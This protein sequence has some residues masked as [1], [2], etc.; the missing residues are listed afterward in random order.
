DFVRPVVRG[1][2]RT[3]V[4]QYTVDEV[5]SSKR[6][7]LERDLDKQVRAVF[8]AKGLILDRFILRNVAFSPEYA[9]AV[10]QKQVALQAKIES[11]YRADAVRKL[12]QGEADA[13]RT[14]AQGQA[15]A[16]TLIAQALAKDKNLLTY[17][18]IQKLSPAIRVMLVPSNAPFILP[19]PT[20]DDQATSATIA[21]PLVSTQTVTST[22]T[23]PGG[24]ANN[25]PT[26]TPTRRP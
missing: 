11:E 25:R 12:A 18:Y 6:L 9:A 26:P 22:L 14:K 15:D 1:L 8:Q 16:L 17:E 13:A 2:V 10:E 19:L 21:P 7:D 3:Q 23:A 5:N 24:P 4:S 20:L